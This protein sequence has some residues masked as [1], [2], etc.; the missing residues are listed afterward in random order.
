VRQQFSPLGFGMPLIA[1]GSIV[2][3]Y[4]AADYV[5][6]RIEHPGPFQFLDRAFGDAIAL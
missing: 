3:M 4:L 2:T 6:S 5:T 1:F